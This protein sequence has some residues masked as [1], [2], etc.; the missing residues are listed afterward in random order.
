MYRQRCRARQAFSQGIR[1]VSDYPGPILLY[2][3]FLIAI[4]IGAGL[5]SC[6]T[7]CITCC[8]AAIPYVGSVI[9][10]PISVTLYAFTLLF[11]RQFGPDFDVWQR[12]PSAE[13][14]PIPASP[15]PPIQ[16]TPP[17]MPPEL[18]A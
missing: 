11:L 15:T 18:P 4:G 10:L 12:I 16:S 17:P 7:I 8:I 1:L 2:V 13:P 5:L 3:L 6:V 9:L 14:A